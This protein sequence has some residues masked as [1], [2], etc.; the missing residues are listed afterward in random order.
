M[1]L[2]VPASQDPDTSSYTRARARLFSNVKARQNLRLVIFAITLVALAGSAWAAFYAYDRGFTKRW[3]KSIIEELAQHGIVATIGKLTIDPME[4][5]VA[6]NVFLYDD[7]KQKRLLA[8]INRISLE[9]DFGKLMRNEHFLSKID[10]K[11]ADLSLPLKPNDTDSATLN[12]RDFSA[13]LLME[14]DRVEITRA[15]GL[16]S[17][18]AFNLQG[19][20]LGYEASSLA[21]RESKSAIRKRILA[22]E[23]RRAFAYSVTQAIE[24][25]E[26]RGAA[27]RVDV[28]VHGDLQDA[29]TLAG[30]IAFSG[31]QIAQR[32]YLVQS[33]KGAMELQRGE[34]ILQHLILN[35]EAGELNLSGAYQI[36]R[37]QVD[38]HIDSSAALPRLLR[39]LN[40]SF[41]ARDLYFNAPPDLTARGTWFWDTPSVV[42][43][44]G[45]APMPFKVIGNARC[46]A[47]EY[48]GTHLGGSFDFNI[49]GDRYYFRNVSIEDTETGGLDGDLL[50][51]PEDSFYDARLRMDPRVL[52]RF[53]HNEE[54]K[55]WL[56]KLDFSDNSSVQVELEGHRNRNSRMLWAHQAE[57]DLR[58][59]TLNGQKI[60]RLE[61]EVTATEKQIVF[62]D[63]RIE[64]NKASAFEPEATWSIA[65]KKLTLK[66]LTSALDPVSTIAIFS[67]VLAQSLSK[68]S[69]DSPPNLQIRGTI[70]PDNIE[71]CDFTVVL[72]SRGDSHC[73]ID[74]YP[75]S[76]SGASGNLQL[77]EGILTLNLTGKSA[78]NTTV[79][80]LTLQE[81]AQVAFGGRF[82][83][84]DNSLPD[85]FKVIA[86]AAD[87]AS[88]QLAGVDFPLSNFE[89]EL[90]ADGPRTQ[91]N[92][93]ANLF[94]GKF[95][96][97]IAIP[98]HHLPGY[99][100]TVTANQVDFGKLARHLT[101]DF[102][103]TGTLNLLCNFSGVGSEPASIDGSGEMKLT[104]GNLFAIPLLGPL[105]PVVA[106]LYKKRPVGY[107]I[108]RE[109][110]SHFKIRN[111]Q[112]ITDDFESSTGAFT[113]LGSGSVDFLNDQVS[114][115]ASLKAR[116]AV[117][118]LIYPISRLFRFSAQGTMAE[119]QWKWLK[120]AENDDS[121]D[122]NADGQ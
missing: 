37:P 64:R 17:G 34:L 81:P 25:F 44:T 63:V 58:D 121:A 49:D 85:A 30:T 71:D 112:L 20:L 70:T 114:L 88:F 84:A 16:L 51:T 113:L 100:S 119:P 68:Y 107:S 5:L 73:T 55:R 118:V 65:E 66:S 117:G 105:S 96:A 52:S 11:N 19:S 14:N 1:P 26:F 32:E 48:Q 92:G 104:D 110:T 95:A 83:L 31:S 40:D 8:K 36:G 24:R 78:P 13:Q 6:R 116:K 97:S 59:F 22:L 12:I 98:S 111:G 9:I 62:E 41:Q 72:T 56:A 67:P 4:G 27:P 10:F 75:L 89:A 50:L 15:S 99:K 82:P 74:R 94:D 57:I 3:R 29:D 103:T 61:S 35:D 90:T 21:F 122:E 47:F 54:L 108:A 106:R 101:P 86:S 69:F 2:P 115:E 76:F 7:P 33:V 53:L 18:V 93:T 43:S 102:E 45:A 42:T 79:E 46:E 120:G 80:G 60:D 109:A 23:K 77:K 38:F 28:E 39:A 91:I 87:G